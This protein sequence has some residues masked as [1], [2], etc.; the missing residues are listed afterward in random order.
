MPETAPS[1]VVAAVLDRC[2]RGE[3]FA[4]DQHRPDKANF[5]ARRSPATAERLSSSLIPTDAAAHNGGVFV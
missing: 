3:L 1:A 5:S 4:A 2:R